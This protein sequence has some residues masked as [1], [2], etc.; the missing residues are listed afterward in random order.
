MS[1]TA[2]TLGF[3]TITLDALIVSVALPAIGKSFDGG[4]VWL[5]WVLDGY[6]LPFAAF[7]LFAGSLSDGFGAKTV[8]TAG[9]ILFSA[10]SALCGIAPRLLPLVVF[11]FVQGA[12]ASLMTPAS[13]AMISEAYKDPAAKG[14]AIGFWAAGGAV[15]SSVS[16]LI[17]GILAYFNWRLIFFV[18]LPVGIVILF[19]LTRISPSPGKKASFDYTGQISSFILLVSLVYGLIQLGD[20]GLKSLQVAV[21]FGIA[22]TSGILFF[23]IESV[24]TEPLLPLKMFRTGAVLTTI[25][26]G[27]AFVVGFFGM[28]FVMSLYLQV[29]RGLTVLQT[30]L[31]FVPVTGFSIFVPVIAAGIAEK[32]GP[33]V[34]VASGLFLMSAGLLLLSGLA[35]ASPVY[36]IVVLMMPVGIGAGMSMP[37]ATSLLLNS[38]PQDISGTAGGVLNTGRQIGGAVGIAVFGT[39]ISARGYEQGLTISLGIS[40]ILLLSL[41]AAG[42][43]FHLAGLKSLHKA[44]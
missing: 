9:I 21:P 26:I 20:R 38:V 1:L 13:L 23:I 2:A 11:R 24:K 41:S 39:L 35:H 22:L 4:M 6:T 37:S 16:P 25:L 15:A 18:N 33:W 43:R 27:F 44:V 42:F 14:R 32:R 36:L 10:G 31:A 17:G 8:F 5:Q 34:P 40:G 3:F 12:G 29:H 7:L 19:I 30:G 28:V